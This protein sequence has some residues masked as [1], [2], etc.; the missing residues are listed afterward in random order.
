[1]REFARA[2]GYVIVSKDCDFRQ[3]AFL[4]GLP[5]VRLAARRERTTDVIVSL[6]RDSIDVVEAFAAGG[7]DALVVLPRL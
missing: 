5:Q 4:L 6:L 2:G 7:D 1:M 3:L